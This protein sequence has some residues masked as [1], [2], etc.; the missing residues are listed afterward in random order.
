MKFGT[1]CILWSLLLTTQSNAQAQ[2]APAGTPGQPV[3]VQVGSG[4]EWRGHLL[5]PLFPE[6]PTAYI[7]KGRPVQ[8]EVDSALAVRL[9]RADGYTILLRTGTG[10]GKGAIIGGAIG[11]GLVIAGALLYNGMDDSAE[12]DGRTGRVI[13]GTVGITAVGALIGGW[14]GSTHAHWQRV[15]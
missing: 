8:C 1:A 11:A 5:A 3:R 6:A 10:A 7:C 2:D 4:D 14:I 12:R 15:W 9:R 13:I